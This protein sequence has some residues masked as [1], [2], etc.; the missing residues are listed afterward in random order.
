M[1]KNTLQALQPLQTPQPAPTALAA[2]RESILEV[3]GDYI[4]EDPARAREIVERDTYLGSEAPGQ[5]SPES[6]VEIYCENGIPSGYF[7]FDFLGEK[8]CEISKAI[9]KRGFAMHCQH[10]NAAVINVYNN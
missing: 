9:Q 8:W 10:H 1:K 7:D 3:L 5:W 2:V 6:V 4:H